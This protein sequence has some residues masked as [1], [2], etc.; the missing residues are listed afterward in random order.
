MVFIPIRLRNQ[1]WE[2]VKSRTKCRWKRFADNAFFFDYPRIAALNA[3]YICYA[4][5][6]FSAQW[7]KYT[8]LLV[9]KGAKSSFQRVFDHAQCECLKHT[10]RLQTV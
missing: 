6:A 2:Y 4:Q 9:S 7:Q 8:G 10:A 3:W 1:N 5:C